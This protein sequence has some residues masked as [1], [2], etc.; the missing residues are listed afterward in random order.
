MRHENLPGE[1]NRIRP[2]A[3]GARQ[4]LDHPALLAPRRTRAC[5]R[6]GPR[7]IMADGYSGTVML[8][9][10]RNS[11]HKFQMN[12]LSKRSLFLSILASLVSGVSLAAYELNNLHRAMTAAHEIGAAVAKGLGGTM[13][14]PTATVSV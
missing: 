12:F 9:G 3:A 2:P 8:V 11:T 13:S 10:R 1:G 14:Q 5:R 7:G 6:A 4:H